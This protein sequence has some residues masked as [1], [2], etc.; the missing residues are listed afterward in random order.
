MLMFLFRFDGW[1]IHDCERTEAAGV[2][3][4]DR[5]P[6]S[7]TPPPT[8]TPRP[9]TGL[10]DQHGE[11]IALRITGGRDKNEGKG[12]SERNER[13]HLLYTCFI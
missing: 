5:P 4:K 1:G 13:E 3:C 12:A 8:T 6:P 10:A 2:Q 9:L 11:N 7:T